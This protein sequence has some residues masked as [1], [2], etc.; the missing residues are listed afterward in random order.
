M[1]GWRF[2]EPLRI[3]EKEWVMYILWSVLI[4]SVAVWIAAA[5]LPG[6]QIK[7]FGDAIVVAIVFGI[8]NF[9]FGWFLFV[10]IGI[11]TIGLG[12]LFAFL[13]RLVVSAL[14]LMLTDALTDRVKINGFGAAFW[15]AAVIATGSFVLERLLK[16]IP[17]LP[18]I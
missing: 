15:G 11:A 16:M 18:G 12:F 3:R 7:R 13:T 10:F 2:S 1:L 5:V 6:I 4:T 14:M 17:G 8:V 9:L